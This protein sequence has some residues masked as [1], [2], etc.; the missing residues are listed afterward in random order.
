MEEVRP[1]ALISRDTVRME[2]GEGT[3]AEPCTSSGAQQG[4]EVRTWVL[5]SCSELRIQMLK[6]PKKEG[7]GKLRRNERA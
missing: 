4:R 2:Q 3:H 7:E 6:L 5:T 1:E